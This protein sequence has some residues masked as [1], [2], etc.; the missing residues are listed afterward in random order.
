M[1]IKIMHMADLHL[2]TPFTGRPEH[3][4]LLRDSQRA[5]FVA[6]VDLALE[7]QVDAVLIAGDLV[8]GD[9]LAHG[10]VHLIEAQLARLVQEN[11]PVCYAHGNHDPARVM[12]QL[13]LP[14]GVEVFT[15]M[16]PRRVTLCDR[17]GNP[18]MDVV[19]VGFGQKVERTEPLRDFPDRRSLPTVG[20]IHT[21]PPELGGG[22]TGFA[23][24]SMQP[25]ARMGYDYWALGHI[26]KREV[27][28]HGR[29]HYPGVLCGRDFGECGG[30][31]VTLV[32]LEEGRE[33]HLEMVELAPIRY[34][35]L[36][37]QLRYHTTLDEIYEQ[38]FDAITALSAK[39]P[40]SRMVVRLTLSGDM[41]AA[42]ELTGPLGEENLDELSRRLCKHT[43]ALEVVM[44]LG[45]ITRGI[46]VEDYVDRPHLLGQM[47]SVWERAMQDDALMNE[48]LTHARTVGIYAG[49]DEETQMRRL[50]ELLPGLDSRLCE[51]MIKEDR[52]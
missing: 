41:E 44:R 22:G 4:A 26:H 14:Q 27:F 6:A 40:G 5:A 20:L 36:A 46:R 11:I 48:I 8:D 1:T 52:G 19:G 42:E 9:N 3:R 29:I 47:L 45:V 7:Q 33:P 28:A 18:M 15:D 16:R 23:P 50:R 38:G 12:P 39:A 25:M 13:V 17:R 24:S 37:I 30:H 43:G 21:L 31:G 51:L 10:T 32:T 34:E 2:D 35:E 49:S